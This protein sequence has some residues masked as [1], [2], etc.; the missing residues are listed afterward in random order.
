MRKLL[1]LF[2][3]V[4]FI[5]SF[6]YAQKSTANIHAKVVDSNGSPLP[7]VTVTLTGDKIAPMTTI[8]TASGNFR[9]LKLPIGT[10]SVKAEL[11]GFEPAVKKLVLHAGDD[12]TF[13]LVLKMGKLTE[14]ITVTAES[15][16]VNTRKATVASNLTQEQLQSIPVPKNI[17]HILDTIPGVLLD[18]LEG[19]GQWGSEV[20]GMGSDRFNSDWT[21]NGAN[22]GAA[23]F[24][25]KMAMSININ[26]VDEVQ[27]SQGADDIETAAGG[28]VVNF[29][30]KRGGNKVSGDSYI[31]VQDED[32][33][34][35]KTLPESMLK[36]H[37]DWVTPGVNRVTQL[38]FNLGGP[39]V[40]DRAWFFISY[41][42]NYVSKRT[43]ANQ[44][45]RGVSPSYLG[46][47][48]FQYGSSSLQLQIVKDKSKA[49]LNTWTDPS[50]FTEGPIQ[51]TVAGT[52]VY[53]ADLD[54]V[55]GNLFVN[56]KYS[57]LTG[58]VVDD[59]RGTDL[60]NGHG[61]GNYGPDKT[62]YQDKDLWV[63]VNGET[64]QIYQGTAPW[65]ERS[66]ERKH[67]KAIA[68]Y[69]VDNFMGGTH[70][71]KVGAT[72]QDGIYLPQIQYPNSR[73]IIIFA[74]GVPGDNGTGS[75][76]TINKYDD[77]WDL[78]GAYTD[79][80]GNIHSKRMGI[81]FQD[82]ATF[83]KLVANIG[84]RYD[85]IWYH[86]GET[87]ANGF[88]LRTYKGPEGAAEPVPEWEPY[89]GPKTVQPYDVKA[90]PSVFSPRLSLNYDISGNGKTVIKL[91]VASYGPK[92]EGQE[93]NMFWPLSFRGIWVPF[94]DMNGNFMPDPGEFDPLTP[95][96]IDMYKA[97]PSL[98]P[99][100][101][102]VG[103]MR[104][105]GFNKYDPEQ[106]TTNVKFADDYKNPTTYEV[107]LGMDKEIFKNFGISA[108][109][110]YKKAVNPKR[111]LWQYPDGE[112]EN[113]SMYKIY[114]TDPVTGQSLWTNTRGSGSVRLI[115]NYHKTHTE[116]LGLKIEA[117]K[118]LADKWM[119]DASLVLQN[120]HWVRDRSE[121]FTFTNWEY[122]EKQGYYPY[123]LNEG[124][125]IHARWIFKINGLFQLP[126]GINFSYNFRIREGYPVFPY[127]GYPKSNLGRTYFFSK[128]QRWGEVRLPANYMLDLGL[129]KSFMVSDNVKAT[130]LF[131]LINADNHFNTEKM[132]WRPGPY[133]GSVIEVNPPGLLQFGFRV[134]F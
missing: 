104:Y 40:K 15:P 11:E 17:D 43:V 96:E 48:N 37:P 109:L 25:G 101:T 56:L 66:Q 49:Y 32:F 52:T 87:T 7:G 85:K 97:N 112:I 10:Y 93:G 41:S 18:T 9:F 84:L 133:Q 21:L 31:Y 88:K 59:P 128:D 82:T 12:A 30:T 28:M 73:L 91:S 19:G 5:I 69:F 42:N 78:F 92:L 55:K 117:V 44:E 2:V 54:I 34:F 86:F 13:T 119:L 39:V 76:P 129:E 74:P 16:V 105:F 120:W 81:F 124:Y 72:Y 116:Y 57:F 134:N 50:Y 89:I 20:V 113:A 131:Y 22:V 64:S 53:Q 14:K 47:L 60:D 27:V 130:L 67:G 6:G 65:W 68:N 123:A 90:I 71:I 95:F 100:P 38:G 111:F 115:T 98:Y 1:T 83:G 63:V 45:K 35:K 77:N 107:I 70:E 51:D 127:G 3:A 33:E 26:A 62:M 102:S 99:N 122:Y 79:N 126:Y 103:V 29:V 108:N 106:T 75:R 46:K 132:E 80:V 118:R 8:T 36:L 114:Y 110:I 58:S 94:W 61:P 23:R 4:A 125:I 24:A 121:Y